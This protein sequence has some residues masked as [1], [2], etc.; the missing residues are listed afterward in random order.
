MSTES[1]W[2]PDPATVIAMA[3]V[4]YGIANLVHEGV[5]HGSACLLAGC[6]PESMSSIHFDGDYTGVSD[7]AQRWIAAAGSIANVMLGVPALLALA[8]ARSPHA[9]W[10]LWMLA[11]VNL[12]QAAGYLLFSGIGNIGD[13]AAVVR[14]WQPAWAWRIG[15]S[16]V[17]AISYLWVARECA[18]AVAALVGGDAVDRER[19]AR[20]MAWITYFTGGV[21]YCASGL[22]N[23]L[24]PILLL[25]SAAAASLGGTSAFLWCTSWLRNPAF[26]ATAAPAAMPG[27]HRGWIVAGVAMAIVFI[28]VMGP[29]IRL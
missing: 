22:L 15:L 9:R 28:I 14:D 19:R 3:V 17:G 18:R 5:G 11:F 7:G 29:G 10:F 24:D 4:A 13:W 2:R 6:R 8:A 26:A 23:P 1:H 27:R 25:I 20:R 16:V 12:L 21:L